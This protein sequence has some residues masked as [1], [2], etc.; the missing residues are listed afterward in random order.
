[1]VFVRLFGCNLTCPGFGGGEAPKYD[2]VQNIND[3]T[4]PAQGCDSAYAWHPT[5]KNLR[6][7]VTVEEMIA[8]IKAVLPDGVF[9]YDNGTSIML[10]WTGGE[11]LMWQPFIQAVMDHPD[12]PAVAEVLFETNGTH[13][14]AMN[15]ETWQGHPAALL[16]ISPKLSNS[17]ETW[18]RRYKHKAFMSYA[19][20][21]PVDDIYLKFVSD[22]SDQSFAEI[23]VWREQLMN[24]VQH[25]MV[26]DNIDAEHEMYDDLNDHLH[27]PAI[28]KVYVMP[29]GVYKEQC[30]AVQGKVVQQCLKHGYNFTPRAHLELFTDLI[31][32]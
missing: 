24:D 19:K 26:L 10:C 15:H 31:G 28:C 7:Q 6:E 8:K 12:M 27:D 11:P 20:H 3:V 13:L 5:F 4:P 2:A 18:A 30:R 1:M 14:W 22:G 17:G 29:E 32:T 16:S 9:N 21:L 23:D 25:Q